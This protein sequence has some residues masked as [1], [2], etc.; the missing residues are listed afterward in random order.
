MGESG[1]LRRIVHDQTGPQNELLTVRVL[2]TPVLEFPRTV[3]IAKNLFE[4]SIEDNN[5]SNNI[6]VDSTILHCKL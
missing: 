6:N 3:G 1:H 4:K 5:V 2:T